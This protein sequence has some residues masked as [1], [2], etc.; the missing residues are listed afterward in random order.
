[1]EIKLMN[2]ANSS[3]D[4]VLEMEMREIGKTGI[5]AS[6]LGF[7]TGDNAGLMVLGASQEQRDAVSLAIDHGINYFDTSPDYGK[8]R[9][10]ENLGRALKGRRQDVLITTKVEIMPADQLRISQKV[11]ESLEHSLRRLDTDY[12]D[13]LMIHNPPCLENDWKRT[14]WAPLTPRD[15]LD[16]KG[17]LVAL[18]QLIKSGNVRIGGIA[19]EDAQPQAL[20]QLVS[21]PAVSILN[22][23]LNMLNPSS[24]LNA[25]THSIHGPVDYR[26]IATMADNNHVAI[27]GFR[28]LGGG[29]LMSA[30]S[31][32]LKRHPIAGG[33]FTRNA[34]H[35]KR[36]V[37]LALQLVSQ[38]GI[39]SSESMAALAYRFNITDPRITTTVAGFSEIDHLKGAIKSLQR[40]A[41]PVDQM[42]KI[43]NVWHQLYMK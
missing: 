28:A 35:Y 1:M 23:W 43:L 19:C 16:E 33:A 7:G 27:A 21:H 31:G 15:F 17:P 38:L 4:Q 29:S 42:Q 20:A 24:L 18:E 14:T 36:E 11:K 32:N 39:D 34:D 2:S 12:I 22:V 40:G 5:K 37:D 13:I 6:V 30:A 9:A 26:D 8:G 3:P 25:D 10:E 41:L